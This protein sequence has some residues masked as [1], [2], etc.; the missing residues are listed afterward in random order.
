MADSQ[1]LQTRC[2]IVDF[3]A[4]ASGGLS[5][6]C[7]VAEELLQSFFFEP[8]AVVALPAY[9]PQESE[10]PA[11]QNDSVSYVRWK[12]ERIEEELR[13]CVDSLLSRRGDATCELLAVVIPRS[14]A[15]LFQAALSR[16]QRDG[17]NAALLI[18]NAEKQETRFGAIRASLTFPTKIS[19][20]VGDQNE[21]D[22]NDP[23]QTIDLVEENA[24]D[25]IRRFVLL[26]QYLGKTERGKAV[27]FTEKREGEDPDPDA[28]PDEWCFQVESIAEL[29]TQTERSDADGLRQYLLTVLGGDLFGFHPRFDDNKPPSSLAPRKRVSETWDRRSKLPYEDDYYQWFRQEFGSRRIGQLFT[30]A[31]WESVCDRT[32]RPR[33]G[34]TLLPVPIQNAIGVARMCRR[35]STWTLE[36]APFACTVVLLSDEAMRSIGVSTSRFSRLIDLRPPTPFNLRNQEVIRAHAELAQSEG[37]LMIVSADDGRLHGIGT[38][39]LDREAPPREVRHSFYSWLSESDTLVFDIRPD[40][41]IHLYGRNGL[42]LDYDG[43]EWIASPMA[44]ASER[45]SKFFARQDREDDPDSEKPLFAQRP[46]AETTAKRSRTLADAMRRLVDANESSIFALLDED[47]VREAGRSAVEMLRPDIRWSSSDRVSISGLDSESLAG[48]LH[49]DGAHL[50]SRDGHV[51]SISRRINTR[52]HRDEIDIVDSDQIERIKK[53]SRSCR[54]NLCQRYWWFPPTPSI[55]VIS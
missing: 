33:I 5:A 53:A 25:A 24:V 6:S 52:T 29:R 55:F 10:Q 28:G 50:I 16:D 17:I 7:L 11:G 49:L 4:S 2:W 8:K 30:E 22:A 40:R 9:L 43:F 47:D 46:S 13:E 32:C 21:D 12:G 34:R 19:T 27:F 20:E 51:L 42:L 1:P 44:Y 37:L 15:D 31:C 14:L 39:R 35:M 26:A 54:R 45:F 3:A 18:A 41:V 36:G 38:S 23:G 48:L